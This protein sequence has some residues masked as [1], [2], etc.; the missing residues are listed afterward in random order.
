MPKP[1]RRGISCQGL[2]AAFEA[3]EAQSSNLIIEA[4]MLQAHQ[5]LDEAAGKYAEAAPIQERL[6]EICEEKGLLEKAWV[7]RNSAVGV[8]ALA[9]NLHRAIALAEAMLARPELPDRLRHHVQNYTQV[10]RSRRAQWTIE[11]SSSRAG[12]NDHGPIT[13]EHD[14]YTGQ[15]YLKVPVPSPELVEPALKAVSMALESLTR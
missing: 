10:L 7:H 5:R 12:A 9:G 4:R 14:P 13:V 1:T 2:D 6:G 3:E 15:T 8:W 11:A